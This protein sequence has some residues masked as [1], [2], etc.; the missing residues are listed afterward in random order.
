M[1]LG[2]D[3]GTTTVSAVLLDE[4][5]RSKAVATHAHQADLVSD[6]DRSEQDPKKLISATDQAV[7]SLDP[8]LRKRAKAIGITGQMH[9]LLLLDD[10]IQPVT[11]LV[12][13]QDRRCLADDFLDKI[14]QISGYALDSGYGCATLSWYLGKKAMP[15]S[16]TTACT[17]SDYL[18]SC[19]AGTTKFTIDPTNAAAWGCFDLHTWQWDVSALQRLGIT[20]ELMPKVLPNYSAAG[21]LCALYAKKWGMRAG[22]PIAVSLGDNQASLL[23]TLTRP[24]E[25]LAITLGTGG[26]VSAVL[27]AREKTEHLRLPQ[28]RWEL[29]PFPGHRYLLVGAALCGGSAWTWLAETIHSWCLDLGMNPPDRDHLFTQLNELGLKADDQ[30]TFLPHFGGERWQTDLRASIHGI[31]FNNFH[32]G[33]VSRALAAGIFTNLKGMLPAGIADHRRRLVASGNALRLNP[34]LRSMAE[35]VF[36]LPILL[37]E[38]TEEAACGA[39][40]HAQKM[41]NDFYMH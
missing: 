41:I 1:F 4:Q 6:P 33:Q 11:P 30:L 32:L 22:I 17:L 31:H 7:L 12:T 15:K 3:L 20:L 10:R 8:D 19:L 39:A 34:L 27:T 40:L 38:R 2:I 21:H 26:Q 28:S 9:G 35:Q 18:V 16:S 14:K 36:H 23:A 29:R 13:W 37:S 25:E 24:E 5:G